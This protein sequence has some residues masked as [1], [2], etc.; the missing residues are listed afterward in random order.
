MA[1]RWDDVIKVL[2]SVNRMFVPIVVSTV[3]NCYETLVVFG[4][5]TV[6]A[7]EDGVSD[8]SFT[9]AVFYASKVVKVEKHLNRTRTVSVMVV[10]VTKVEI[11]SS[12]AG[13]NLEIA[14]ITHTARNL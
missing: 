14:V 11:S 13:G 10:W 4:N 3:E 2:R 9:D 1:V 12:I 5:V 6:M 7:Y 8:E